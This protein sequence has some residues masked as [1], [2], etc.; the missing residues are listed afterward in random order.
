MKWEA[1]FTGTTLKL[2][3]ISEE[4]GFVIEAIYSGEVYLYE[5]P[6]YGGEVRFKK[7]Y[8]NVCKAI[9]AAMQM[10]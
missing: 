1:E 5:V 3:N 8:D 4:G 10:T 9:I 6:H 7:Q 2:S